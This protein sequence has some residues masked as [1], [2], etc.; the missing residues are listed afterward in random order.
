MN[1]CVIV[2]HQFNRTFFKGANTVRVSV[3]EILETQ[4]MTVDH[5]PLEPFVCL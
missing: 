2:D 1:N 3:F 5:L 4:M